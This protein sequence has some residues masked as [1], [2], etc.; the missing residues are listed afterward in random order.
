M[1]GKLSIHDTHR[2]PYHNAKITAKQLSDSTT[3]VRFRTFTGEVIGLEVRT[4]SRGYCCQSDGTPYVDGV[5]VEEDAII[6]AVM[7]DGSS[8]SWTVGSESDVT[9]FDGKLYGRVIE[10]PSEYSDDD[11]VIGT[12]HY[13]KLF[14]ANQ[15]NDSPLSLED[16]AN[17]PS[18]NKWTEDQQIERFNVASVTKSV[19]VYIKA[20]TKVLI[21]MNDNPCNLT[22]TYPNE[23]VVWLH[24]TLDEQHKTRFGRNFS[25]VNLTGMAISL[26]NA[27]GAKA[28][29]GVVQYG[30]G[31]QV[32]ET[33]PAAPSGSDIGGTAV[34]IA[35]DNWE[36]ASNGGVVYT[37]PSNATNATGNRDYIVLNDSTP[38]ILNIAGVQNAANVSIKPI[39]LK[40]EGS[41]GTFRRIILRRFDGY[42][43]PLRI[44]SENGDTLGVLPP[45]GDIE[46][47]V[48]RDADGN[49]H[50]G[51]VNNIR[52]WL[53]QQ[54]INLLVNNKNYVAAGIGSVLVN[55]ASA[56]TAFTS[57][58]SSLVFSRGVSESYRIEF[59]ANPAPC[60]IQL[61]DETGL[62]VDS[63]CVP[64]QGGLVVVQNIYGVVKVI[65]KSWTDFAV[66]STYDDNNWRS[67]F[68]S[69]DAIADLAYL[70]TQ[71][72]QIFAFDRGKRNQD[73]YLKFPIVSGQT[74][75]VRVKMPFYSS[76]IES[77]N[78]HV[79]L[80]IGD[81]ENNNTRIESLVL[82]NDAKMDED[83]FIAGG[84]TLT[85]TLTRSGTTVTFNKISVE[86]YK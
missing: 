3:P 60:W 15:Q 77:G 86:P 29:I 72:S 17:V 24:A 50:E 85:G 61:E 20:Q 46:I 38:P 22:Q 53:Q 21:L 27:D 11:V 70:T 45:F 35:V 73:L 59:S 5:F 6:T 84:W 57:Y 12:T 14:S 16:L 81:L 25:V 32:A 75:L 41:N 67:E 7:P 28:P 71:T 19:S 68:K 58:K 43:R 52:P 1:A 55:A 49:S 76:T 13:K 74:A 40:Y 64:A 56:T 54:T 62:S 69:F 31:L 80:H 9:V 8:T 44:D 63:F 30:K 33:Y 82:F 78:K 48:T 23:F 83:A 18:F 34:F 65:E 66:T 4:N 26:K 47:T 51:N 39:M 36:L 10:D 79:Y 2:L 42:N 37:I